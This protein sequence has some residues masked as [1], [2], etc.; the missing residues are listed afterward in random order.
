MQIACTFIALILDYGILKLLQD[1]SLPEGVIP[2]KVLTQSGAEHVHHASIG[3]EAEGDSAVT[4]LPGG[5]GHGRT[6]AHARAGAG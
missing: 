6:G 4:H 3:E 2:S 1:H 5:G